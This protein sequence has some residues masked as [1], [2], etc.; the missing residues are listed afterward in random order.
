[1]DLCVQ[2]G[3]LCMI[4]VSNWSD[5]CWKYVCIMYVYVNNVAWIKVQIKF[6]INL[7]VSKQLFKNSRCIRYL[8]FRPNFIVSIFIC[9]FIFIHAIRLP[10]YCADD[11]AL[12]SLACLAGKPSHVATTHFCNS[13]RE[14][15]RN[16]R[17][18]RPSKQI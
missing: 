6:W 13:S 12:V 5:C 1:M 10:L 2:E 16:T 17:K 8:L 9:Y 4:A 3:A 15:L 11:K 14:F 18:D 7:N